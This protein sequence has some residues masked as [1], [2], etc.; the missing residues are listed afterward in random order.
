[1]HPSTLPLHLIGSTLSHTTS[2][3]IIVVS[4]HELSLA[5]LYEVHVD[6]TS[7]LCLTCCIS[8]TVSTGF[9]ALALLAQGWGFGSSACTVV[10]L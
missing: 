8:S 7:G 4:H 1:M 9:L 10:Y 3:E 6:V 2:T 5:Y